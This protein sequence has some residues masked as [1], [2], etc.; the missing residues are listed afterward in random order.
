MPAMS[1][2]NQKSTGACVNPA[3][4]Q[5]ELDVPIKGDGTDRCLM[6]RGPLKPRETSSRPPKEA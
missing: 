6:C 3:C 5:F 4:D 1:K 2:D